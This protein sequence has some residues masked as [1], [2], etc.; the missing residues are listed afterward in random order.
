MQA[1]GLELFAQRPVVSITTV[2]APPGIDSEKLVKLL[3]EKYGVT[4]VGG[5]DAA[6]GKIFRI[7]HLGYFDDFDI[8]TAVAAI[9]RGLADLGYQAKPFGTGVGAAMKTMAEFD[10]AGR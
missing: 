8:V 7:A 9:E 6:K 10:A 1:L 5:Q 4:L 3:I 2:T